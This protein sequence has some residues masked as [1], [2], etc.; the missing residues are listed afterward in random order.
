MH[1]H[2]ESDATY[3]CEGLAKLLLWATESD[4]AAV[5][6][7]GRDLHPHSC[8]LQDLLQDQPTRP[9][10]VLVL[11]L[12]HLNRHRGH[13]AVLQEICRTW[14]NNEATKGYLQKV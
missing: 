13:S 6:L 3:L 4:S 7:S 9:N 14:L 11:A 1:A 5:R 8:G 12:P 2:S 10:N